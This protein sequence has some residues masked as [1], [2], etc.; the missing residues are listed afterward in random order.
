MSEPEYQLDLFVLVPGKDEQ[1]TI[2]TLL[3]ERHHSLGIRPLKH[4]SVVHPRRDSGCFR[5]APQFLRNFASLARYALVLF[6]HVGSGREKDDAQWV[7]ED[8]LKRLATN[9][10]SDRASV[11]VIQPELE[12]WV[13][14]DSPKVDAALGWQGHEPRLRDWLADEGMWPRSQTKPEDPKGAVQQALREVRVPRS[15]SIYASIA[16]GVSVERCSDASFV[17]LKRSLQAWF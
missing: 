8:L 17:E 12:A 4:Q 3:R 5:E 1:K 15:S 10:W 14:S 13:W 16:R 11:I 6:D 9:G 2:D 7:R